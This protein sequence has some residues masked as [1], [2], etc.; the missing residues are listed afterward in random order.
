MQK[1]SPFQS[2]WLSQRDRS[3][4]AS[5]QV[6]TGRLKKC[7]EINVHCIAFH[8]RMRPCAHIFIT[9]SCM[10]AGKEIS[11]PSWVSARA[12]VCRQIWAM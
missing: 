1:L 11:N 7:H 3:A 5:L 4:S 2:K 10:S 6:R 8:E 12:K 9:F